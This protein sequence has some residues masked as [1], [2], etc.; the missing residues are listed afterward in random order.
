MNKFKQQIEYYFGKDVGNFFFYDGNCSYYDVLPTDE[1]AINCW[2]W[3]SLVDV[4]Y[5]PD[6]QNPY[7]VEIQ[8]N[9]IF[10]KAESDTLAM[11]IKHICSPLGGVFNQKVV[12]N[13]IA[14]NFSII[15]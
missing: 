14:I 15:F 10:Y 12:P 7:Y 1:S 13:S 3:N 2:D 9:D 8:V 5:Y 11:A 6:T 4:R